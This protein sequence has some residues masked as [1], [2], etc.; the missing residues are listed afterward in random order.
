[1]H[2]HAH[3][4][5][6]PLTLDGVDSGLLDVRLLSPLDL[7]VS[8]LGRFSDQDRDDILALARLKLV[9]CG[10]LRRRAQEAIAGYVGDI[11]RIQGTIDVACRILDGL[12][13]RS[14][15]RRA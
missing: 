5:S 4:D 9:D 12:E 1:M 2:E 7:T 8:K 11:N 6:I 13:K 14:P 15:K 10:G 3:E